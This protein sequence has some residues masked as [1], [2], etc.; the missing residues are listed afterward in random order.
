MPEGTPGRKSFAA[1]PRQRKH[2]WRK[3]ALHLR[4]IFPFTGLIHACFVFTDIFIY[5]EISIFLADTI[6]LWL[7]FYN[8]M[9]LNKVCIMIEMA[10]QVLITLISVTH[11]Q[12]G[13]QSGAASNGTVILFIFQMFLCYPLMSALIGKRL[14]T[15]MQQQYAW[16][17]ERKQKTVKGKIEMKVRKLAKERS[18]PVIQRRLNEFL[19]D[20]EDDE[21]P[22]PGQKNGQ[23]LQK[24]CG[25]DND[26]GTDEEG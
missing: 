26:S 5:G 14:Q 19:H 9:L 18:G 1:I 15:H 4:K 12:R 2:F 6:L 16:K 24:D 21:D 3:E 20:P 17:M 22:Q 10:I 11:I 8:F 7:D 25:G 23:T 13:L